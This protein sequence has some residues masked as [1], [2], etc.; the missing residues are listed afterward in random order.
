MYDPPREVGKGSQQLQKSGWGVAVPGGSPFQTWRSRRRATSPAMSWMPLTSWDALLRL[1]EKCPLGL[2]QQQPGRL[3][4][5]WFGGGEGKE[6][7][8][9]EPN[10][11]RVWI[12]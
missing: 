9:Y 7:E 4:W 6:I 3:G 11:A 1:R 10:L 2:S 8:R 5:W 12:C